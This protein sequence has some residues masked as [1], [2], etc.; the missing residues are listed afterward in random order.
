[1]AEDMSVSD[2]EEES[3]SVPAVAVVLGAAGLIPFV[4]GAVAFHLDGAIADALRTIFIPY[5]V[6]ILS[7]TGAIHFGLAMGPGE[8]GRIM[9]RAMQ[10]I[11]SVAP[12][13]W[14]LA[15]IYFA[16]DRAGLLLSLG[17]GLVLA[18]DMRAVRDGA[19]PRWYPRLRVP[20]TVVVVVCFAAHSA[21]IG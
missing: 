16:P 6:I 20:L 15:T 2:V 12:A 7:F 8:P 4:A 1:M 9:S 5:G 18:F 14:A 17:F 11:F 21:A 3:R 13:L 10:F 19:A